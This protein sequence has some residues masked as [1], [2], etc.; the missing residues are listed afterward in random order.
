MFIH[1]EICMGSNGNIFKSSL[2]SKF[3]LSPFARIIMHKLRSWDQT[4]SIR[5]DNIC[6]NSNFTARRIKK[7]WGRDSKVI[8]GPVEVEKFNYQRNR[9]IFI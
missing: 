2:I 5:I 9:K 4:S 6:T 7:Y 8:F 1:N 3:G